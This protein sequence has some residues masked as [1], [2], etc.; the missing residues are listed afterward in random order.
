MIEKVNPMHPDKIADRIAGAIV[1]FAYKKEERPKVAVEVLLGHGNCHIIAESSIPF[2]YD[3]VEAIVNRIVGHEVKLDLQVVPQDKHL[4]DN[5][6]KEIRCGDNGIFK[7]MRMNEEETMLSKIAKYIYSKHPYDGKYI[8]DMAS[9]TL[10]VCQ[11]NAK[12][13][14]LRKELEWTNIKNIVINPLGAW[15]GGP[16]SDGGLTG[17]K[18]GSDIYRAVT[19]GGLH[20][21]D[22]SKADVSINVYLHMLAQERKDNELPMIECMC[23]IGDKSV[24]IDGKKISYSEI[25]KK[26]LDY[27]QNDI[28]GFEKMAEW[29]LT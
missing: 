5:Q 3:E 25:T 28:G 13:E 7:G 26:A 11:S 16:D 12:E 29:G 1:D 23:A 8:Y 17:R 20:G 4:A 24:V 19:G 27:I 18:I 14:D 6:S 9:S 15:T 2:F 21:K 22:I 10:I